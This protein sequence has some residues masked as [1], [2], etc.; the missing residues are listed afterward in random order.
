MIVVDERSNIERG[1]KIMLGIFYDWIIEIRDSIRRHYYTKRVKK[2]CMRCGENLRVNYLSN[3]SENTILKNHVNF[4]GMTI[5]G[6]GRVIIGNWF[7]SGEQC[8]M[9]SQN[10]KYD[11]GNAIPYDD[12][13]YICKNIIIEDFVWLGSRVKV[14]PGVRIGEGAI[15]QAGAVVSSDIPPYAIAGGNPAKV[16]KYRDIES[17]KQLKREKKF[18]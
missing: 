4:N 16:F 9:I 13:Q 7:H 6:G 5:R 11:R 18:C 10:H 2:Q 17:Y 15:I 8:F 3:V 1:Q 14:L 12:T